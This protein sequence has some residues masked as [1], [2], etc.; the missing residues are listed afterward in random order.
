[1]MMGRKIE[2][3]RNCP[4]CGSTLDLDVVNVQCKNSDCPSRKIGLIL[5][6]CSNV[7]IANLGYQSLESLYHAGLLDKGI[8]SLYKLREKRDQIEDL[9]GFGR[10]KT[11]KIVVEIDGKRRLRD[12]EILGSIG[13]EG[14]SLRTFQQIFNVIPYQSFIDLIGERGMSTMKD[15][16][17]GIDG[18]GEKKAEILVNYLGNPGNQKNL[19]KLLDCLSVEPTYGA[20]SSKKLGVV[21][22]SGFR[23]SELTSELE[24]LG[25][26]VGDNVTGQTTHL[27]VKDPDSSSG[28]SVKAKSL[29]IPVMTVEEFQE[30][31]IGRG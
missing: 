19:M 21:V 24:K 1:M 14:I 30:N 13:I 18:I 15:K 22:F 8:R 5:N 29:G 23:S 20:G 16:L 31:V 28:K 4:S 2:F 26:K 9:P 12:W 6:W 17:I 11:R 3:I 27:L 7:K 25:W 10:L